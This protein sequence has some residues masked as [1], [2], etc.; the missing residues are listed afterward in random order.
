MSFQHD[1]LKQFLGFWIIFKG[2][3]DEQQRILG[4][5]LSN[6]ML[7]GAG[8]SF[9]HLLKRM[10]KKTASPLLIFLFVYALLLVISDKIQVK[11]YA[12]LSTGE[13]D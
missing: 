6:V 9:W 13:S 5:D 7:R 4:Y 10:G 8:N 12:S 3:R 11:C 1:R 2:H